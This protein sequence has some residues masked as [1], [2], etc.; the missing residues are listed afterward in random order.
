VKVGS[1]VNV[2]GRIRRMEEIVLADPN[3]DLLNQL[4]RIAD[5]LSKPSPSPW[6]EWAK[7]LASFVAGIAL[8]F[9]G[10]ALQG[11][12]GDMREQR[13]MRRIIY[14]ELTH[15]FLCLFDL[16]SGLRAETKSAR[17]PNSEGKI[18]PPSVQM[19]NPPFTFEGEDYM[20]EH[21]SVSYELSEMVALK[22]MY[23]DLRL[24]S[25]G[26]TVMLG[27][28]EGTLMN[29]GKAFRSDEVI[30][31]NF[32]K[33]NGNRFI[34]IEAIANHFADHEIKPEDLM[35]LV[36]KEKPSGDSA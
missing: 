6:I 35:I 2:R 19:V 28:L 12:L 4:T 5:A 24:M 26:Q 16:A 31:N 3:A 25:P 23:D 9:I 10:I 21:R 15:S 34:E 29:F 18:H 30:R 32:R 13:K 27:E 1:A 36:M 20:R 7:T 33:F 22:R 11:K 17:V 14:V 8:T